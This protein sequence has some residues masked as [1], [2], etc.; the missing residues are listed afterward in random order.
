MS[1]AAR[2]AAGVTVVLLALGSVACGGD[3]APVPMMPGPMMTPSSEPPAGDA[4]DGYGGMMAGS[5]TATTDVRHTGPVAGEALDAGAI[6]ALQGAVD[7]GAQ[8]W[9]LDPEMT[10]VAF[11]RG[12]FGWMMPR[13]QRVGPDT[14]M[15]DDGAGGAVGLHLEQLG[16]TGPDGVW[17]VAGGA[18]LR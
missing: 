10:A 12:R 7:Q 6:A 14:V 3:P 4:G 15:V 5:R 9:R 16:R 17:T 8:P 1:I 11:V 13:P 18:W 2:M